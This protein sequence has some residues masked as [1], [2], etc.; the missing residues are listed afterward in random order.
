M[1]IKTWFKILFYKYDKYPKLIHLKYNLIIHMYEMFSEAGK[2][3]Q[4][5]VAQGPTPP[6]LSKLDNGLNWWLNNC[7]LIPT[8]QFSG[9]I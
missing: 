5:R 6:S 2:L 8:S 7:S 1:F 9:N 4:G 3:A